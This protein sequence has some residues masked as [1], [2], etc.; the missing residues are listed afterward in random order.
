MHSEDVKEW[1]SGYVGLMMECEHQ[2]EQLLRMK[3]REILPPSFREPDGA[4][5]TSAAGDRMAAAVVR[6]LDREPKIQAIIDRCE[7][8]MQAME[9]AVD[10]LPDP[11]ERTVLRCRYFDG[12]VD[13][14]TGCHTWTRE[15]WRT[16]AL[17]MYGS[18]EA[19][20]IRTVERIHRL[21]LGHLSKNSVPFVG[22]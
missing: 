22:K 10:A 5:H 2:R 17:S 14:E 7:A 19:R 16:V 13:P 6:R 3:S 12:C 20:Y 1:L 18:D 11:L 4:Q 8:E 21:A 15:K 9:E